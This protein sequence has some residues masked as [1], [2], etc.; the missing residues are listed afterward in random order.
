MEK[1]D[2]C[3]TELVKGKGH[4]R[5]GHEDPE[6]ECRYSSTLSLTSA[7]DGGVVN[8]TPRPFY[9]GN[10]PVPI[11]YEGGCAPGPVWKGSENFASS[12]FDTRTV[13]PIASCS[14]NCSTPAHNRTG[15]LS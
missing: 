12:G 1:V 4:P 14:N 11:T 9:P 5:T 2:I 6:G 10:G 3:T 8:V 7:L 13:Q 15:M